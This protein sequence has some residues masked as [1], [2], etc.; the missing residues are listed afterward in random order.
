MPIRSVSGNTG[1]STQFGNPIVQRHIA[2]YPR[3]LLDV[4]QR[5]EELPPAEVKAGAVG[6]RLGRNL[7]DPKGAFRAHGNSVAADGLTNLYIVLA[8]FAHLQN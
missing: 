8:R 4:P 7:R 6:E 2:E 3:H 5:Q 1:K